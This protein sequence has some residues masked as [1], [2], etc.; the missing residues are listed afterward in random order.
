MWETPTP[1]IRTHRVVGSIIGIPVEWVEIISRFRQQLIEIQRGVDSVRVGFH[2][3]R[4]LGLCEQTWEKYSDAVGGEEEASGGCSV[5]VNA[6]GRTRSG[7]GGGIAQCQVCCC[8]VEIGVC[9][10]RRGGCGV[11]V[12]LWEQEHDVEN[13]RSA[14]IARVTEFHYSF[15]SPWHNETRGCIIGY[16]DGTSQIDVGHGDVGDCEALCVVGEEKDDVMQPIFGN[17]TVDAKRQGSKAI[18]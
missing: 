8:V 7:G 5:A 14:G 18:D 13:G 16:V 1:K 10:S 12:D 3:H 6:E 15:P 2:I 11:G 9:D 4:K 17:A